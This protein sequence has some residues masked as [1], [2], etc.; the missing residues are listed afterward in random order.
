M[1][2]KFFP[3]ASKK[4]AAGKQIHAIRAVKQSR[5]FKKTNSAFD[6]RKIFT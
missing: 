4:I 2:T 3:E 1:N 6:L 5:D